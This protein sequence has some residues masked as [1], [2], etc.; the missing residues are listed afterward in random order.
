MACSLNHI[1]ATLDNCEESFSGIGSRIYVALVADLTKAD[2]KKSDTAAEFTP[3]SFKSL[4]GKIYAIDI[5][6]ESGEISY[7]TN[8]DGGGFTNQIQFTVAKNMHAMSFNMRTLNNVKFLAFAPDGDDG[9]Y[10][11]YSVMGSAKISEGT[12]TTGNTTDSDHGHTTTISAGPMFYPMMKWKPVG[13]G[14]TPVDLDDWLKE[15]A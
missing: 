4:E 10:T 2:V 14:S 9:Y 6:E 5:K 13:E 12:G 7:T 15:R 11:F 3:D 8:P 1:E